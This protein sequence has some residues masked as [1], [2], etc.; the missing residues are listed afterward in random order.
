MEVCSGTVRINIK[1]TICISP[2]LFIFKLFKPGTAVGAGL[3]S[4]RSLEE[5]AALKP[6]PGSVCLF[7]TGRDYPE[8]SG[9]LLSFYQRI[10]IQR[11][12]RKHGKKIS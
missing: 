2:L 5:N 6:L 10:E 3:A 4:W 11:I 7:Y 12:E 9:N 1:I 8:G